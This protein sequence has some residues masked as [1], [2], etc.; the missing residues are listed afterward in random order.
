M[1]E[2]LTFRFLNMGDKKHS[3]TWWSHG[4][5]GPKLLIPTALLRTQ[6]LVV[7][8]CVLLG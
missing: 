2:D 5:F 1:G 8:M 3:T 7:T 6:I 4:Q